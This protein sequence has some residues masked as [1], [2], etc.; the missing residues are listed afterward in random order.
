MAGFHVR[1]RMY[2][3]DEAFLENVRLEAE[4]NLVR[5]RNHPSIVLWCGNN[6]I[7]SAWAH[8]EENGGWGWKKDYTEEL[9]EKIWSDYEKVFHE[10]LPEAVTGYAP[11]A[12]YWPSSPLVSLSHD[13]E[14]HANPSTTSGDIHYWGVWHN[15]EPFDNYNVYVGRFMSE[16][17]FQSFPEPK[18]VRTYAEDGDMELESTVMLAHQKNGAGNRLIKTYMDQYYNEPKDFEAFLHMSQIQQA[19]A[20]KMAIEAHRR[21]KPY[22]MGTLYWQMNDCW[23]VASWAGMDYLGR[24][25]ARNMWP[26]AVSGM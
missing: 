14:Q 2:P 15:T 21:N 23:P 4:E 19:E 1:L 10:I 24:W 13:K 25:K 22:C 7:D 20:M 17:G 3:G 5:L 8:Y 18:T 16:Y 26:S 6:E 11:G 12:E 9:R